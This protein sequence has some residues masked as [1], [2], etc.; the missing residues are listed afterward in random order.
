MC[1]THIRV[2][3]NAQTNKND[4]DAMDAKN[5]EIEK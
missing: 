3:I 5:N 2:L 1:S 4:L